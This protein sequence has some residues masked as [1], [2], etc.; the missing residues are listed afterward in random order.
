LFYASEEAAR[1]WIDT[2]AAAVAAGGDTTLATRTELLFW[3]LWV[4]GPVAAAGVRE[5]VAVMDRTP[6]DL[7]SAAAA[8]LATARAGLPDA[9]A[10]M[11]RADSLAD[12]LPGANGIGWGL[13]SLAR[14]H[15]AAGDRRGALATLARRALDPVYGPG[16][17]AGYLYDE[18]RLALLEGD[19]ARALRA[20]RHLLALRDDPDPA[21]R[22]QVAM[23][24]RV[25]DSLS[26]N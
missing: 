25:V 3:R 10:R 12:L 11:R 1:S 15:E 8:C 22:P 18:G 20:W 4:G 23:L 16:Y 26:R 5:Y 2:L 17:L 14:C 24:R 9:A 19:G 21:L 13:L 6:G 7:S